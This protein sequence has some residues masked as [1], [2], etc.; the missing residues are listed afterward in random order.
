MN[1]GSHEV[2]RYS[3]RWLAIT[4][5]HRLHPAPCEHLALWAA[6]TP[7]SGTPGSDS[8]CPRC[9]S[10][11]LWPPCRR[12]TGPEDPRLPRRESGSWTRCRPT[13]CCCCCSYLDESRLVFNPPVSLARR[14]CESVSRLKPR[15]GEKRK[16][17]MTVFQ[18]VSAA[19]SL[20]CGFPALIVPHNACWYLYVQRKRT[21]TLT[22]WHLAVCWRLL[23]DRTAQ[24]DTSVFTSMTK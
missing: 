20:S 9:T 19:D 23:S 4:R 7:S 5:F 11:T 14:Q 16:I 13:C 18:T 1:D 8:A 22:Q 21:Q 10:P 17:T 2:W 24:Q 15:K 6:T 12:H 3:A